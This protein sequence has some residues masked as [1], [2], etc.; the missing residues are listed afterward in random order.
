M[1]EQQLTDTI[2]AIATPLAEGAMSV[3]RISGPEAV[4]IASGRLD[5]DRSD[6][7]ILRAQEVGQQL[8]ILRGEQRHADLCVRSL[9]QQFNSAVLS[10][11][12]R[13]RRD[14]AVGNLQDPALLIRQQAHGVDEHRVQQL[15]G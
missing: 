10:V 7:G 5:V 3:I 1:K 14:P 4:A 13:Q 15:D 2:A 12:F 8:R 6:A 11:L 9:Q